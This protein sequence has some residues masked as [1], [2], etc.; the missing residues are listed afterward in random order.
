MKITTVEKGIILGTQEIA[1]T[2]DKTQ[3]TVEFEDAASA[4]GYVIVKNG[5][6]YEKYT[7]G[8][9]SLTSNQE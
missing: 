4:K 8:D 2:T 7:D 3:F 1:M 5:E 9:I 6:N